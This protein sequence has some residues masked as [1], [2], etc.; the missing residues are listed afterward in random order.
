M[1]LFT[2]LLAILALSTSAFAERVTITL[3]ATTDLHG[4]ILPYDYFAGK[5]VDRGLAKLAT[6]IRAVR[7]E[8]P[9][10]LLIDCGDTIQGSPI[11]SVYQ[12]FVRTGRLPLNLKFAGEPFRVDPMMLAMN[13]IGFD[14]MVLGNHEFNFGLKNLQK[15][16]SEA[17]FPWLSANTSASGPAR[18]F[19]PAL[20]KTLAGIRIAVVGVTTPAIPMWE[21][22]ENYAGYKF[23][24]A[25]K[26][27]AAAVATLQAKERPD[28]IIGAVHAGLDRDLKSGEV[29]PGEMPGENSV[30]QVASAAPALDAIVFGHTHREL[31]S[32]LLGKVLLMQ[33]KNWGVSLGRIDFVFEGS[34][35]HWKL[36]SKTSSLI[37]V[38]RE[39]P[40]DAEIERLA[41]PYH[42][43]TERYL[44]TKVADSPTDLDGSLAR[45]QDSALLDAVNQAQLHYTK[46]DVSFTALFN[47]RVRIPKGPLTVRQ[48]AAL[49]IYDNELYAIEGTGKTVRDALENAARFFL[50][51]KDESCAGSPLINR[52]VLPFNFDIAAGVE[53]EIDLRK[54]A[55]ARIT[56][57]N[58]RGA[59][60]RD[61]QKLRI[62][63]N[64][65]R[66]GGSGGYTM[67]RDCPIVWRAPQEI[68]ELII[69]YYSGAHKLPAQ[70]D[71]NWKIVPEAAHQSLEREARAEAARSAT[72]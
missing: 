3:L 19:Q 48:I 6:L 9:N 46:A 65:Y 51:C 43:V 50:S 31:A 26:A 5:P 4:S 16:R 64:N 21:K 42:E 53:Y 67:F 22:P 7:A 45:I 49:Y 70:A 25:D 69:E 40:L 24:P 39:T 54:P 61:D 13:A 34:P 30:Y 29:R 55:G 56:K 1:H 62:A 38:T 28:L 71:G 11:E 52:D 32:H 58:Y 41:Q 14:A 36:A 37:P 59:P 18:P 68:R 20:V 17:K 8:N 47:P 72:R 60:L 33:P 23:G 27:M 10:T 66:A 57:L 44:A 2:L 15:A 63:I 12:Q 35:G